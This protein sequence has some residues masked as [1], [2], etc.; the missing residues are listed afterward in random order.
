MMAPMA[1]IDAI[2]QKQREF[3]EQAEQDERN[4]KKN[5]SRLVEMFLSLGDSCRI[6]ASSRHDASLAEAKHLAAAR[7]EKL[8]SMEAQAVRDGQTLAE[9]PRRRAGRTG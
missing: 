3:A 2:E 5:V 4:R 9:R 7:W 6:L 8:V 1:P